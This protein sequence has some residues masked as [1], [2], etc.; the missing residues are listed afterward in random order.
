[1]TSSQWCDLGVRRFVLVAALLGLC[2][3]AFVYG[4]T[5][6]DQPIHSDGYS[7]YVYVPSVL[8][9]RDTSLVLLANDWYGGTYPGFTGIL[10]SPST[11]RFLNPHPIGTAVMMAPFVGLGHI[12]SW[13]SNFPLDGFS[14][15][16]Q[17]A[18]GL[19]G[20]FYMLAGLAVLRRVL[21]RHFPAPIV[22]ATLIITTWGTN[23]FHYGVFDA[24]FSHAFAFFLVCALI[25][26]TEGWWD[27]P[28]PWPSI[29][30]GGVSALLVL[31]RHTDALFLAIVPLYGVTPATSLRDHFAELWRRRRP[32]ALTAVV[33]LV[34]VFP[35]LLFYRRATGAWLAS[36]YSAVGTGFNF[37]SPHLFGVLFS[38]QKGLFFWSPALLLT[39]LG[40]F[41]TRA[42]VRN[43]LAGAVLALVAETWLVAS[44]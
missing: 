25:A 42:R 33:T 28:G 22:L 14:F 19:A 20:L 18:A 38:T 10:P 12:L 23:L 2:G 41:V 13:W 8:L 6:A 1:M 24:T 16:Y 35:Q 4:R 11:G 31:T 7:Y 32:L 5:N 17:H 30:L 21:S 40:F 15:F 36:P 29:A 44:W 9:Y 3:Y 26:L 27:Q 43:L 39:I 34:G 37:S